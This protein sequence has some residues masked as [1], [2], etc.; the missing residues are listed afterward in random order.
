LKGLCLFWEKEWG[1][2]NK[3]S[4]CERIIPLVDGWIRMNSQLKPMQDGAPSHAAAST[5]KEL[6][7]RLINLID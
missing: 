2:I 4:Y 1:S 5:I 7:K 6:H 3:D